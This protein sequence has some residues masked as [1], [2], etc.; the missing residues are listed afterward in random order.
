MTEPSVSLE[1]IYTLLNA[2]EFIDIKN[3][4][5]TALQYKSP[6][7]KLLVTA[8]MGL[9]DQEIYHIMI[10]FIMNEPEVNFKHDDFVIYN[11]MFNGSI[12]GVRELFS[13]KHLVLLSQL[14]ENL[15]EVFSRQGD[16]W[17]ERIQQHIYNLNIAQSK[18]LDLKIAR[19]PLDPFEGVDKL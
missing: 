10:H 15:T 1:T 14:D 12:V 13:D 2:G 17:K 5:Y 4:F 9:S 7:N 19:F 8:I 3:P 16:K 18:L 6:N 11:H